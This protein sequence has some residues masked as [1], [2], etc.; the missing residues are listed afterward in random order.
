M[1]QEAINLIEIS[2]VQMQDAYLDLGGLRKENKVTYRPVPSGF[3]PMETDGT[4]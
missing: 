3:R 2:E 1:R 4:D